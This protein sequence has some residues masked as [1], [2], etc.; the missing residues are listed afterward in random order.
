MSRVNKLLSTTKANGSPVNKYEC[1][2]CKEGQGWIFNP[3]TNSAKPCKCQEGK[4]YKAILS[5]SGIT[6]AFMKRNFD[7][8][9]PKNKSQQLAKTKAID[10]ANKFE[11]I[12]ADRNN[13]IAFLCQVGS[14][15]THLSI[16][17]ANV[18][19]QNNIGV[20]YMQYREAIITL[21]QNVIDEEVYQREMDKYKQAPVLLIDDLFKGKVTEADI[22]LVYEII[23]YRYLKG[24]PIIVSSEYRTEQLLEYDEAI[25]SR[26]IEM[27]KGRIFEFEGTELNHRLG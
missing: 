12:R 2:I 20:R 22:N 27:C 5:S 13:S 8:Y 15:K 7:T 9:T 19:M 25:G 23:N 16:S 24:M 10:Y 1:D 17:I 26:I 3:E 18:L 14:G 4:R 11:S 21:K 6:E